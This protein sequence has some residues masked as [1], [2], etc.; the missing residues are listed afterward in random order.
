MFKYPIMFVVILLW[1]QQL[2]YIDI[3]RYVFVTLSF[4]HEKM[5]LKKFIL[6]GMVWKMTKSRVPMIMY[7]R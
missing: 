4:L 6:L 1:I 5:T 3:V 2:I 7:K